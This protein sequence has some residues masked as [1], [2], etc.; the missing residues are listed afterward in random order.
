M[1]TAMSKEGVYA[2]ATHNIVLINFS[3]ALLYWL[4]A[5]G[6]QLFAIPPDYA[7]PIWP[8][9]G[10]ALGF[11]IIYGYRVFPGIF[12]GA[13]ASNLNNII[14]NDPSLGMAQVTFAAL[15]ALGAGLQ[16]LIALY[17][18][19]QNRLLP[20]QLTK[21]WDISLFLLIAGPLSCLFNSFNGTSMLVLFDLIP[22]A[23]W[24][25]NWLA[26][27]IGDSVGALIATP[28][29]L[30]IINPQAHTNKRAWHSSLLPVFFLLLIIITFFFIKNMEQNNRRTYVAD[31]GQQVEKL[32]QLKLNEVHFLLNSITSFYQSSNDVTLDEF[33]LYCSSITKNNPSAF[34]IEWLPLVNR[35]NRASWELKLQKFRFFFSAPITFR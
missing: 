1:I 29:I 19:K 7:S 12:F 23:S 32:L 31:I 15:I 34:A 30:R 11:A 10:I 21:G 2:Q 16:A 33:N 5:L 3:L 24:P 27:W 18:L 4:V 6:T 14:L 25:N 28:L 8:S 35:E 26:W 17:F 20:H 9:S 22:L 13:F